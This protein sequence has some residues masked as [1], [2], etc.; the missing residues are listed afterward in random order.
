MSGMTTYISSLAS[1]ALDLLF[2]LAIF[3]RVA[4]P[5]GATCALI[6]ILF[7]AWRRDR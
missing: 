5:I 4:L 1:L 3:A 7:F 6:Y 2:Y